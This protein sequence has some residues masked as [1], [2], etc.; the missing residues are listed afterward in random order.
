MPHTLDIFLGDRRVGTITNLTDDHNVF[1]FDHAYVEDAARPILS[2]G[3]LN[4]K[5]EL[6]PPTRPPQVRLLPFFANLLPEGH[7]RNYL[8]ARARVNPVRDF[9]LLWLLGEDLPG[10]V[11]ARHSAGVGAPPQGIDDVISKEVQSDPNVLKFSLAGVQLKFSAI[12]EANGGL[13]IP[14]HGKGGKWIVKMPSATYAL[15]PENEFT[16][17]TFARR[18]GIDVPD[19][20]L[21]EAAQVANLPPEV[22]KD[23]GKA[24]Y[25]QRFDRDGDQRIHIEDFAQIFNQYPNN[26]YENVSYAN[27][28]SGIWRAMGEEQAKEF[29]R[30]LVFS[31][32]IGNADMHLKNWSVI[33]PDGKTPQLAPA[34]DYLSTIVYIP[35]DKLALTI[36]RTKEWG[37]VSEELL[38]RFAR[39]ADVPRGVVL[40][41][42]REMVQRIR[43]AWPHLNDPHLLPADF[44]ETLNRHIERIPLFTHHRAP[45]PSHTHPAQPGETPQTEIA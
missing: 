9:P 32:G 7:L 33:Y 17:L 37:D 30:R 34:Y 25:I 14:V 26:K 43:D 39:R 5:G 15:V 16:M 44:V 13:T 12:R 41:A 38:E 1:V 3:L 6:A 2:L 20:G 4:A 21:V 23:L 35:N 45:A 8:A 19:V 40:E 42:A 27:M 28:L 24:L 31:I 29:I 11:V 22:R 36:A 18:V 10:A